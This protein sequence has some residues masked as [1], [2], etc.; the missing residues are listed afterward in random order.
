LRGAISWQ[1][2]GN[3][4]GSW[5]LCFFDDTLLSVPLFLF[6]VWTSQWLGFNSC[7][8]LFFLD[9]S[10]IYFLGGNPALP[11]FLFR[12]S[13]FLSFLWAV[14][15]FLLAES[16]GDLVAIVT[17]PNSYLPHGIVGICEEA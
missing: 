2:G 12:L 8:S 13:W 3:G 15:V 5:Q 11:L 1:Y 9:T 7:L 4:S 16:P 6:P 17:C 10:E 14:L